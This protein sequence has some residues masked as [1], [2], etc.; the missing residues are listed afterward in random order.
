[1]ICQLYFNKAAFKKYGIHRKANIPFS[2]A[3]VES[4]KE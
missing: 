1:M 4:R 2:V 3:G